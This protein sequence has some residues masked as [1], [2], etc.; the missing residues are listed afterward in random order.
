MVA[1]EREPN[2]AVVATRASRREERGGERSRRS[3]ASAAGWADEQIRVYRAHR[4]GAELRHGAVLSDHL[5]EELGRDVGDRGG[6]HSPRRS[7][8]AART[9]AATSSIEPVP[10]MITQPA[11]SLAAIVR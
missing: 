11:G 9:A 7:R 5:G 1:L 6:A 3:P 2:G 10:S 4:G 8:T